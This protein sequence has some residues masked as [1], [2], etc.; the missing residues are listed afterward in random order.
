MP[1]G[2]FAFDLV[3]QVR[4]ANWNLPHGYSTHEHMSELYQPIRPAGSTQTSTVRA[5]FGWAVVHAPY[6]GG[7]HPWYICLS[8]DSLPGRSLSH[9]ALRRKLGTILS[10][11]N[12]GSHRSIGVLPT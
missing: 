4:C 11:W 7:K 10:R 12:N 3:E 2:Q 6:D 5:Q 1:T 9:G 8:R